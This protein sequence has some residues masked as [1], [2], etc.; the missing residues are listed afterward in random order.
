MK[1]ETSKKHF[2]VCINNQGYETSLEPRK[3]YEIISDA[4]AASKKMIRIVDESGEDYLYPAQLF[5]GINLPAMVQ[6]A[7]AA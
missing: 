5:I 4:S 6:R 7:L 3:I 1:R 2:V